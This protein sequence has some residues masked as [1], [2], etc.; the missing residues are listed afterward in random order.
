MI[1]KTSPIDL[2]PVMAAF[3]TRSQAELAKIMSVAQPTVS[4]WGSQPAGHGIRGKLRAEA[5]RRGIDP[6]LLGLD[7]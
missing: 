3:G 7:E 6:A 5:M 1:H 2:E 4:F